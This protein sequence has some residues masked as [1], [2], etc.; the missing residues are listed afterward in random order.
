[1]RSP[2]LKLNISMTIHCYPERVLKNCKFLYIKLKGGGLPAQWLKLPTAGFKNVLCL[3][4]NYGMAGLELDNIYNLFF[5]F[6]CKKCKDRI[7]HPPNWKWS[8]K[9]QQTQDKKYSKNQDC[10]F[11]AISDS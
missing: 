8:F 6:N 4:H 5:T 9:W 11:G 3:K 7:S 10:D 1:M 2:F